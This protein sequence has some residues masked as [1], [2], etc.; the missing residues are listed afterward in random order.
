MR[1]K[2]RSAIELAKM[3]ASGS[4]PVATD[5]LGPER[6][7]AEWRV[8]MLT[9]PI[10][11]LG[12]IFRHR[13]QF[14]L[15]SGSGKVKGSN[16]FFSNFFWGGFALDDSNAFDSIDHRGVLLVDYDQIENSPFTRGKILDRVRTTANPNIHLGE[17]YYSLGSHSMGPY[18]F[19]LTRIEP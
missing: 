4:C 11:S 18:Y 17:F 7:L 9:G 12:G 6:H 19:S 3:F 15:A 16:L 5:L 2:G 13:K 8:D 1:L 10:P 14:Y